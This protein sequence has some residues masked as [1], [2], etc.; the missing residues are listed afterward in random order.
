MDKTPLGSAQHHASNALA[1][2]GL[3][4]LI[5]FNIL[6]FVLHIFP[7]VAWQAVAIAG[8]LFFAYVNFKNTL[9]ENSP[10]K[11]YGAMIGILIT[12]AVYAYP[13]G[14]AHIHQP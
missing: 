6:A 7:V 3:A 2:A 13:I 14:V 4:V 12:A 10:W 5:A 11:S 9:E 1:I 8:T